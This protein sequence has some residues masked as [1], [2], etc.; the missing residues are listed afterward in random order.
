MA[1]KYVKDAYNAFKVPRKEHI[2]YI[3]QLNMATR[4]DMVVLCLLTWYNE[5]ALER[6]ASFA[7]KGPEVP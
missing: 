3:G 5:L 7:Q 4:V 1:N 2:K 6:K